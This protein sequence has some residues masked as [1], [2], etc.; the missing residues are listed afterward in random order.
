MVVQIFFKLSI[1]GLNTHDIMSEQSFI[2]M[3]A[4]VHDSN[5]SS[6]NYSLCVCTFFFFITV[7]VSQYYNLTVTPSV[8][9][10]HNICCR[11]IVFFLLMWC[12][13]C[14]YGVEPRECV[15]V[16]QFSTPEL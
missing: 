5:S 13:V 1:K 15:G 7:T 4:F 2:E 10:L 9:Y 12:E 6:S 11:T 14:L 3:V 16:L 8:F